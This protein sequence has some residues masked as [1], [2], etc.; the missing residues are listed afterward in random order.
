MAREQYS[1]LTNSSKKSA[2]NKISYEI[3]YALCRLIAKEIDF[4]KEW[5]I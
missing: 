2:L 1:V 3:E 5:D 4:L